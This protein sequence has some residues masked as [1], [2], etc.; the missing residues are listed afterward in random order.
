MASV[1]N[2]D[3]FSLLD[4]KNVIGCAFDLNSCLWASIDAYYDPAYKGS[5]NSLMC[6]RN[7]TTPS[8]SCNPISTRFHY[9]GT[10]F[11]NPKTTVT[12][13]KGTYSWAWQIGTHFTFTKS[14]DDFTVSCYGNNTS[15]STWSDTLIF[16]LNDGQKANFGVVQMTSPG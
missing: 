12:Y 14:G 6:F 9:N 5:K 15:G 16:T 7:Y 11:D 13:A 10:S 1:P 4:V 3:T 2:T 8:I